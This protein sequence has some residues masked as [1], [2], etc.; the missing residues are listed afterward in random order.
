[1]AHDGYIYRNWADLSIV[2]GLHM[3]NLIP[4]ALPDIA[5]AA[6]ADC[7][8]AQSQGVMQAPALI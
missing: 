5:L 1:M 2:L 4:D 7:H 6:T 3:Q 8:Q